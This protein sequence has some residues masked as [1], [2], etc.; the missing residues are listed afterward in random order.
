M[1]SRPEQGTPFFTLT[2]V[3]IGIDCASVLQG[4]AVTEQ[5]ESGESGGA[6]LAVRLI[7]ER[8]RRVLAG[9]A[10]VDLGPDRGDLFDLGIIPFA[11]CAAEISLVG[12][13]TGF[14]LGVDL[15]QWSI[16]EFENDAAGL[17]E[18]DRLIRATV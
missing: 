8:L 12:M 10:R 16:W 18:L 4:G 3:V 9:R 1:R 6:P 7:A 5:Q 11:P 13:G 2:L 15:K 17:K 14:V